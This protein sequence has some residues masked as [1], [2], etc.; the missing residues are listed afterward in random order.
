MLLCISIGTPLGAQ[1]TLRVG[2]RVQA[3]VI[4]PNE[5]NESWCIG[6]ITALQGDTLVLAPN[7]SCPRGTY[8]TNIRVR[9]VRAD[10]S[11]LLEHA[12]R[13]L[14]VGA[15]VGGVVGRIVDGGGCR[16]A[17]C[18][19]PV[20]VYTALGVEMGAIFG[21]FI[22]LVRAAPHWVDEEGKRPIRIGRL[23]LHPGLRVSVAAHGR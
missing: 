22:G 11:S 13:G 12:G 15:L 1:D 3:S 17:G 4:R 9:V 16:V 23:D 14:L 5:V 18:D 20:G 10:S 7:K 2:D 21:T 19:L 6:P 8:T